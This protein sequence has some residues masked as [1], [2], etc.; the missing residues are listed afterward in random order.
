MLCLLRSLAWR[1]GPPHLFEESLHVFLG[2]DGDAHEILY[3]LDLEMSDQD[4]PLLQG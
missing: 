3:P 2:P 1:K 4:S